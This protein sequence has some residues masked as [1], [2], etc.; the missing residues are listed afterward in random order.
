MRRCSPLIDARHH[1]G[2]VQ[3]ATSDAEISPSGSNQAGD[4]MLIS[5]SD[6]RLNVYSNLNQGCAG[7]AARRVSESDEMRRQTERNGTERNGTEW[8]GTGNIGK[9]VNGQQL[10][11]SG[12]PEIPERLLKE[13]KEK[14]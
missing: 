3:Q 1:D 12:E 7:V 2:L 8:K 9:R 4:T 10:R 13:C 5:P 6:E 14:R 11:A